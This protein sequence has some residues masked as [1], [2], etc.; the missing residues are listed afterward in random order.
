LAAII[1]TKGGD[2]MKKFSRR[3]LVA[4][5]LMSGL[6]LVSSCSTLPKPKPGLYVNKDFC[7]SVDYPEKWQ[8]Q[9]FLAPVE[10]LRVANPTEYKLPVLVVTIV[11]K[12][13]GAQ[14]KD[15]AKGWI[16]GVK[17]SFPGSKRFKV[18]SQ[19]MIKLADGTPAAAF[20]LKWNWSDGVTKLQTASVV[21]FV[22]DKSV[23][24]SATTVLGGDTRPDKLL[25]MCRTL[26]FYK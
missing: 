20:T 26:R 14:L 9:K 19:E 21:A 12:P 16:E 15:A 5:V 25:E 11:D 4:L 2:E 1:N 3:L 10:V 8:D 22:K 24:A 6:A 7:F 17:K 18:L 23:S 13:K